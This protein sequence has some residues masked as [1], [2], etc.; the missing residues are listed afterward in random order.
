MNNKKQ[1][2]DSFRKTS[3]MVTKFTNTLGFKV[4]DEITKT[5]FLIPQK[6]QQN[7]RQ[8]RLVQDPN[9]VT[10][11]AVSFHMA[12]GKIN[13]FPLH[14]ENSNKSPELL[15]IMAKKN[16]EITNL[17]HLTCHKENNQTYYSLNK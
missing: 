1:N 15:Q 3:R 8:V 17:N 4:K 13:T 10:K 11:V 9:S 12:N 7:I 6:L 16:Y 2:L 5:S 14:C